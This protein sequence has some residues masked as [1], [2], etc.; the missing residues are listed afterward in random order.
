MKFAVGYPVRPDWCEPLPELIADYH[1]HVAEVYV[2]WP[3]D[4]SGRPEPDND[5]KG[6][7]EQREQVS[8]DL[9]ALREMG[10]AIDL[11]FNAACYGGEA[12]SRALETHVCSVMEQAGPID[13]VTT[14]SPAVAFVVGRHFPE[15]DVRASVN[16]RLGTVTAMEQLA[17]L[18]DSF[19][20]QRDMQRNTEHVRRLRSWAD[21]N[22]KR[23]SML[24]NSGCLR[25]CAFQSFHDNAI[26]H[27]DELGQSEPLDGFEPLACH[28]ILG[29]QRR[30][31]A[32]LQATWIRPEDL[33][34]YAPLV[35]TFKLATRT[36]DSPRLVLDAYANR[37]YHGNLLD[38]LEPGYGRMMAPH[39]IDNDQFPNDWFDRTRQC[40]GQCEDC[41]YCRETLARALL[42]VQENRPT[43]VACRAVGEVSDPRRI[44][45]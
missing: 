42:V 6:L 17:E 10:V 40:G 41:D 3:G 9:A 14:T 25:W 20:I 19:Y 34:H 44:E 45:G 35:D 38:L 30:W 32:L 26:A 11:L 33:H 23:L 15:V 4:P 13:V 8:D 36:H 16:M 7:R 5:A 39:I 29:Q 37:R 18:F 21:A 12:A 1:P 31:E 27:A 22:G 28:R 2:A 24:A 43:G